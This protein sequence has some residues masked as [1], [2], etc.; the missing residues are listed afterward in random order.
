MSCEDKRGFEVAGIDPEVVLNSI[1][2]TDS[3]WEVSLSYTKS[4][5]A[6]HD[7]KKIENAS[8]KVLNL[9]SGQSFFLTEKENG[10]YSRQLNP[11]EGHEYELS[12]EIE[13]ENIVRASTYVPSVLDVEVLSQAQLDEYGEP[14]LEIDIA[15]SDNPNEQNFYVWDLRPFE[16]EEIEDLPL[17]N[18]SSEIPSVVTGDKLDKDYVNSLEDPLSIRPDFAESDTYEYVRGGGSDIGDKGRTKSFNSSTYLSDINA[19]GGKIYNRLLLK[20]EILADI[21]ITDNVIVATQ[22][23]Q[24]VNGKKP[25]FQLNVRAVSSELYEYLQTYETYRQSNIKNTSVVSP[26]EIYSN[27]ENGTGIF[28]GYNLKTFNI[29]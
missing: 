9:T 23:T 12:I 20:S 1:I 26:S 3:T 29:Y 8:V 11:V 28:G 6:Q 14:T 22:G 5:T 25:I 13:N 27:I 2:S 10:S 21:N 16:S 19:V 17:L 7:F 15:I 4:I 18:P 24:A